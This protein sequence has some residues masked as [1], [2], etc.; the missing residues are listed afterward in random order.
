MAQNPL[1]MRASTQ[2]RYET[3]SALTA[4]FQDGRLSSAELGDR[5]ALLHEAN[6]YLDLRNLVDDLPHSL[7]FL[8]PNPVPGVQT[9]SARKS[10]HAVA[11]GI[12]RVALLVYAAF[13]LL[14]VLGTGAWLILVVVLGLSWFRQQRQS[15]YGSSVLFKSHGGHSPLYKPRDGSRNY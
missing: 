5:L 7:S 15:H 10:G 6:T 12:V 1:L 13:C 14:F 11:R 8:D 9:E 4:S 2:D 3:E